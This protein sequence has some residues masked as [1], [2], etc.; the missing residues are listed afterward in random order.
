MQEF[1][2]TT[3]E[4][5]TTTATARLTGLDIEILYR[6]AAEDQAE[7]V[8]INLRAPSSFEAFGCALEAA[9]PFAF[10]ARAAQLAWL[11]WLETARTLALPWQVVPRLPR[12][13]GDTT[14]RSALERSN[15]KEGRPNAI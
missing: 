9:N 12:P 3:A 7:H 4:T 11:P 1:K 14:S 2:N 10:W 8:S 6:R 15:W 5:E 13:T